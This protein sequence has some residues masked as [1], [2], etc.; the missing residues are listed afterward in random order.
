VQDS[1]G[2]LLGVQEAIGYL[3][4]YRRQL[5]ICWGAGGNWLSVGNAGPYELK[6]L[7]V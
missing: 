6:E 1:I 5:A 2:Y 4:G 3:L 7:L